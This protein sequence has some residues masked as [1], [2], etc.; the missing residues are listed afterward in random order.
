MAMLLMRMAIE[1]YGVA[2]LPLSAVTDE[3]ERGQLVL[4]GGDEWKA[5]L[6]I[7]SYCSIANQNPTMRDLW[8]TLETASRAGP[9]PH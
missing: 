6:E 2:W 3:L 8:K 7:R 1:G 4:A 5:R 9:L